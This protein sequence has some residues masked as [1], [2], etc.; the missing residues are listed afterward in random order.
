ME[1]FKSA[2]TALLLGSL[3]GKTFHHYDK[4]DLIYKDYFT[5][6][7]LISCY[8]KVLNFSRVSS[9]QTQHQA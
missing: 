5:L 3:M 2:N 1:M 7:R 9:P 6:K 4:T 8:Y